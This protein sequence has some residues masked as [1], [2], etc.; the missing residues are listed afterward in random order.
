MNITATLLAQIA[1]FI[2]LIWM[3][4][5]LMWG[6]ITQALKKRQENISE[7]LL[8][9]DK[10]KKELADAEVRIAE[11]EKDARNNAAEIIANSEKRAHEI[12]EENDS[13]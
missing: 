8:A 6:P 13:A 4:N 2:I 7:G 11:M 9:A 5:R 10:S 1:A 3:V 12:I